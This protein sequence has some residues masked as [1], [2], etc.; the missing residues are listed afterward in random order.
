MVKRNLCLALAAAAF[1]SAAASAAASGNNAAADPQIN[2]V[3]VIGTHNSYVVPADS[4]V[5]ALM[6]PKL[7]AIYQSM[8]AHL[9]E[10]RRAVMAEEHPGGISDPAL[11]LDYVQMPLEAQ[12]RTGARSIELDLHP[13][14]QGGLYADPLPYR[15][16]RAQ[17]VSDLAPIDTQALQQPGMKVLHVADLDFRSQ[18][19]ALRDCL[20]LMRRWSDANPGHS[21]V[22]VL[23]EPKSSVLDKAV[24]GATAV[25]PFDATAFAEIDDT[26]RAV[27]GAERLLVPDDLRGKH[28]T[29]E[30]AALAKAWPKV[31]E[32]RG[33]FLFF[34]LVPGMN[35]AMFRNYMADRP[36]LEGRVAFVQGLPGMAHTA[37]VLVDNALTRPDRIPDLVRA[38]YMVRSRA[39]IDT[40]EARR[41]DT[42]R[43]DKTLAS[44]AQIISTD[45]LTAPNVHGT[46]YHLRPFS[47]GWR[48]NPVSAAKGCKP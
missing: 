15:Q 12:L 38:G 43:R 40:D 23:L 3:Q 34:Y 1:W 4:R 35:L 25:P 48:C 28:R 16:L 36:S 41:N 11:S 14:P 7:A 39:D 29:L 13:D 30:A 6:A 37:F 18:C 45:Y 31:S 27:L 33:K 20:S 8:I 21:P 17:G 22:F 44:G 42:D 26:I 46:E 9:P 2:E 10:D 47:G 19:P 24:P 5:M 32:T